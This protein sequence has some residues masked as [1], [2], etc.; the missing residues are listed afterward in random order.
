MEQSVNQ[1]INRFKDSEVLPHEAAH[2]EHDS[3]EDNE[4][5]EGDEPNRIV[6]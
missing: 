4:A 3:M 5:M 6:T 2:Y 1:Q